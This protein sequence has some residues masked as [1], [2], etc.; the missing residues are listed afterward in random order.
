MAATRARVAPARDRGVPAG[1]QRRARV[2]P[3]AFRST[4]GTSAARRGSSATCRVA[5]RRRRAQHA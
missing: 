4:G 5:R 3:L 1:A 2:R